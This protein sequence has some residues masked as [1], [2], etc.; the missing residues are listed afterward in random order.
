LYKGYPF[1]SLLFWRTKAQL[2]TERKLGPF[3]LPERDPDYPIDYV[4]DGQQRITSVFGVFQSELKAEE[5]QDWTQVYFDFKAGPSA[6]ASQF[7]ILPPEDVDKTK[8]FPLNSLFETVA[9]RKA[10]EGLD[11]ETVKKI[12]V[13]QEKFK[14]ASIPVQSFETEDRTTVAIVFERVNRKGVPLDTLQL[15]SAWTWSDEFDLQQEFTDL[16]TELEPFGFH[17]VGDDTELVLRCCA[18]V[19]AGDA[20]PDTLVNLDGAKVRSRFEEVVNG[21]KGAI[22]FIRMNLNVHSLDNLPFQTLIVPLASFFAV[23]LNQAVKVNDV[24]RSRLIRWFWRTCFSRRYSSGVLRNLKADI[25]QVKKLKAGEAS[26]LGDFNVSIGKDFFKE[27]NFKID[28]VNTKTFVLLLANESPLSLVSG[29]SI[30]LA[31]VLRDYNRNEFHHLY[32]RAFL[33]SIKYS[34]TYTNALSNFCFLSKIDNISLGGEAPSIYRKK[35]PTG[36]R[37]AEVLQHAVCPESLFED[38]FDL[39]LDQRAVALAKL[40]DQRVS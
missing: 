37:L 23:P 14:E 8:H 1:G 2:K 27:N 39:F 25:E 40:A 5:L 4:L 21:I 18:A 36:N 17:E 20:S 38:N 31:E 34:G 32:P 7:V 11:A 16:T 30:N 33:K 29:A 12:D 28:S 26:T 13:L 3:V 22:D 6:Q 15:L 35:M 9:Y 19:M 10:C 24:Q